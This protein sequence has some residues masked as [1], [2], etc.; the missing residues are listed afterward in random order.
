MLTIGSQTEPPHGRKQLTLNLGQISSEH[1]H[2]AKYFRL[3]V[4][5]G[6]SFKTSWPIRC[7][8]QD[9]LYRIILNEKKGFLF[10]KAA[11]VKKLSSIL[12]YVH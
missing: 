9:N 10:G 3:Q 11:S 5:L 2:R 7:F 4:G 8:T 12:K 1:N 6:L